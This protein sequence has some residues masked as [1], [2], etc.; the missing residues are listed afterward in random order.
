MAVIDSTVE[1]EPEPKAGPVTE[2]SQRDPEADPPSEREAGGGAPGREPVGVLR[3][4]SFVALSVVAV[5]QGAYSMGA[6]AYWGLTSDQGAQYYL[7]KITAEG[8]VPLVD[9]KH[10]WNAGSWWIGGLLYRL[11]GGDPTVWTFFNNRLF[12]STLAAILL[13]GIGLR[14]RLHPAAMAALVFACLFIVRPLSVKYMLPVAWAFALLP[15]P[16]LDRGPQRVIVRAAVPAA[17]LWV[18]VELAVLL[19]AA[20]I[21]YE[22]LAAENWAMRE[23]VLR[24]ASVAGGLVLGFVT[25][26]AYFDLVHGVSVADFNAQVGFGQAEEFPN[27]FGWPFFSTPP[28][29]N[30]YTVVALFPALV[31]L[32]FVPYVWQRLSGPTRFAAF[33]AVCIATVAIRRPGPGHGGT[34]GVLVALAVILAVCDLQGER[35]ALR[36]RLPPLAVLGAIVGVALG[37][38]VTTGVVKVGFD[39]DGFAGPAVLVG[40]CAAVAVAV[41]LVRTSWVATSAGALAVLTVLPI[42]TTVNRVDRMADTNLEFEMTETLGDAVEPEVD[43][44]LGDTDEALIIP[45][46]L[47][48][49][50]RLDLTNPTP[51]YLFHYDFGRNKAD[52]LDAFETGRVPAV[53]LSMGIPANLPWLKEA[54]VDNYHRCAKVGIVDPGHAV[55]VWVHQSRPTQDLVVRVEADGT[56]TVTPSDLPPS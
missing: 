36:R 21:L 11:A 22:L 18:H 24:A 41:A 19:S 1:G 40:A 5:A 46:A 25:E 15:T 34:V 53:I 20:T 29:S 9:F 50:D 8:A 49:Y 47:P 35:F 4:A 37:A 10:G 45:T 7:S 26:A 52:V 2:G 3:W 32:P 27:Q 42:A 13:A 44:C 39:T 31:L 30:Q 17:L 23:R 43:R 6:L 12:A 56:R 55:E 38:A 51:Y 54:L 48:L 33:C 14:L 16:W 28:M